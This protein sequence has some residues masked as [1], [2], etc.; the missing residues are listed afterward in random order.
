M[1]RRPVIKFKLLSGN[2]KLPSYA[3]NDDAGLDLYSV[4]DKILKPGERYTFNL[5]VSS[6]IPPGYYVSF[7]DKSGLAAK[8][9]THVLGGVVDA[10]YRGEWGVVLA[11]LGQEKVEIEKGDKI[12]QGLLQ[13]VEH[14]RIVESNN[15][16][17]TKRG[18][19]GFGSTGKK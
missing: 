3:H 18:E 1:A 7:R 15:L 14:A 4:E 5:G 9:G 8:S 2:A 16:S 12:A 10:G 11:N 13:A 6:E 17:R 19:G